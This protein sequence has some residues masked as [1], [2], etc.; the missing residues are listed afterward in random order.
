MLFQV[1]S[2][3]FQQRQ[4]F[5]LQACLLKFSSHKGF[6]WSDHQSRYCLFLSTFVGIFLSSFGKEIA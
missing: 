4:T 3:L 2:F 5:Q 6:A 1:S